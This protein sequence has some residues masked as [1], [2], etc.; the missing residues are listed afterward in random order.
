M[1]MNKSMI[2]ILKVTTCVCRNS[3]SFSL[4]E[5]D[6]HATSKSDLTCHPSCTVP[7]GK[8]RLVSIHGA[9]LHFADLQTKGEVVKDQPPPF[10]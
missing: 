7:N 9:E 2:G 10:S 1:I 3:K 5:D 6:V 8:G 4:C